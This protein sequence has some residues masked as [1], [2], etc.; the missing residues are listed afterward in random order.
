MLECG[1][2]RVVERK[3]K[4]FLICKRTWSEEDL[5]EYKIMKRAVKRKVREARKRVNEEWTLSIAKN[6]KENKKKFRSE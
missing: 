2:R 6:F 1:I 4:Y 3:K 5:E